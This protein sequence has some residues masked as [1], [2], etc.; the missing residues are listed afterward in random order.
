MRWT[1]P[2]TISLSESEPLPPL[3]RP[4]PYMNWSQQCR[5]ARSPNSS[6]TNNAA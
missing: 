2:M 5:V 4:E 1:G 6:P 3:Y